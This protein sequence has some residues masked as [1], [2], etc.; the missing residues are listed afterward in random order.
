MVLLGP[1]HKIKLH[2]PSRIKLL[3]LLTF[4]RLKTEKKSVVNKADLL[5]LVL[6][7]F[8]APIRSKAGTIEF[9]NQLNLRVKFRCGLEPID[10]HHPI[11]LR[12]IEA[13]TK[14]SHRSI[15]VTRC[16]NVTVYSQHLCN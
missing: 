6:R 15:M 7:V 8:D 5:A 1:Q 10:V 9:K 4:L 13:L 2:D 16:T 3:K 14:L 11:D 12:L